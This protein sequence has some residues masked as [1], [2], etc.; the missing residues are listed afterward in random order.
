MIKQ[1]IINLI[2]K[3]RIST[4]EVADA[5]GKKGVL[6]YILP[7]NQGIHKVGELQFFYAYNNSNWE[8]HEQIQAF[9]EGNI[10]LACL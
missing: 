8:L 10:A 7:I 6:P 1:E 3:N 9:E 2:R 5:L 4:T